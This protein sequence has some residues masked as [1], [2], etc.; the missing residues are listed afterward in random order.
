[1]TASVDPIQHLSD[2]VAE[3][4]PEPIHFT[5]FELDEWPEGL[6][7]A[8]SSKGV[9]KR[10]TRARAVR[11]PGCEWQCSKPVDVRHNASRNSLAAYIDCDGRA[12]PRQ[13]PS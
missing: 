6:E 10:S 11:C 7:E 8:F 1:M 9:F 13:D 12:W 5:G 3:R 4:H 2:R